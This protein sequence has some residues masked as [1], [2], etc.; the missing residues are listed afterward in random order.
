MQTKFDK[1][2]VKH[3]V[4]W[5]QQQWGI[6]DWAMFFVILVGSFLIYVGWDVYLLSNAAPPHPNCSLTEF[7]TTMPPPKRL[8]VVDYKDKQSLVWIAERHPVIVRS[9][10]TYYLFDSEGVLI[11]WVAESGEG[12]ELDDVL[13]Q[14]YETGEP[15][16]LDEASD[17]FLKK[18]DRE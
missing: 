17:R 8:L 15:I 12:A 1:S 7:S 3:P 18:Q 5:W 4:H 16:T 9:G 11:D 10:P 2:G 14:A 13:A 6:R